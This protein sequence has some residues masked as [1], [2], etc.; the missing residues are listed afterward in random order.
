MSAIKG[1]KREVR[2]GG[3]KFVGL[4]E[5]TVIAV[6]PDKEE[7]AEMGINVDDEPEYLGEQ[8]NEKYA[9]IAFFLREQNT[10]AVGS[11]SFFLKN[12]EIVFEDKDGNEKGTLW[13][14]D[15]GTTTFLEKGKSED[16]LPSWFVKDSEVRQCLE[17]EDQ[18]YTFLKNWI[19]LD[20]FDAETSM[21]FDIKKLLKGNVRD[22]RE[23][24]DNDLTK[25]F[26][27]KK[28]ESFPATLLLLST[29]KTKQDGT[30]VQIINS[31]YII[32]G[33]NI[34]FFQGKK[35][36]RKDF[37]DVIALLEKKPKDKDDWD[38]LKKFKQWQKFAGE[39][40]KEQYGVKEFFG[41]YLGVI[42]E[43]DPAENVAAGDD[44]LVDAGNDGGPGYGEL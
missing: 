10:K 41:N 19:Q 7:L 44:T 11:I 34:K 4:G 35:Y 23:F 33:Y 18:L 30:E 38:A 1:K 28:N 15:K 2:D 42:R 20:F 13:I 22:L 3:Q 26:D 17:G 25:I 27:K 8:E 5:W 37:K 43:Y 36:T 14:N 6:N 21:V 29:I 32:P 31:K 9:R 12:K 40:L 39:I 24:V 16:D